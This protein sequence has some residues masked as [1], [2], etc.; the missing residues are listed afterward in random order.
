M[1]AAPSAAASGVKLELESGRPAVKLEDEDESAGAPPPPLAPPPF[2]LPVVPPAFVPP[3]LLPRYGK[4]LGNTRI[5]RRVT[6]IVNTNE[7][8]SLHVFVGPPPPPKVANIKIHDDLSVAFTDPYVPAPPQMQVMKTLADALMTR[9]H[10]IVEA[11]TGTGK[12]AAVFTPLLA[13]QAQQ[14]QR[15]GDSS[16]DSVLRIIYVARTLPQLDKTG[17]ELATYPYSV[18]L[19]APVAKEHLCMLP[20]EK[21]ITRADQCRAACKPLSEKLKAQL[22][23]QMPGVVRSTGCEFLDMQNQKELPNSRID[24]Y[25]TGGALAGSTV[26]EVKARAAA[27]GICAY[28]VSRDL[29]NTEGANVVMLTYGQLFDPHLRACNKTD[30]LLQN[31][32]VFI[33]EAHNVPDVSRRVASETLNCKQLTDLR[34]LG[35]LQ[36]A[37]MHKLLTALAKP[38]YS[39]PDKKL[40]HRDVGTAIEIVHTVLRLIGYLMAW[41]QEQAGTIQKQGLAPIVNLSP[42]CWSQDNLT[43][44]ASLPGQY[45]QDLICAAV[46]NSGAMHRPVPPAAESPAAMPADASSPAAMPADAASVRSP[47]PAGSPNAAGVASPPPAPSPAFE[48]RLHV[49]NVLKTLDVLADCLN[50]V[51][52]VLA[53]TDYKVSGRRQR[54]PTGRFV[55]LLSKL[56]M[57]VGAN[58]DSFALVLRCLTPHGAELDRRKPVEKRNKALPELNFACLTASLAMRRVLQLARCAVFAS[59]TLGAPL[60]FALEVGMDPLGYS[61]RT[62]DHHE[63]VKTQFLPLVYR[64]HHGKPLRITAEKLEQ[65][66][67]DLP[68]QGVIDETGDVLMRCAPNV[69]GGILVFFGSKNASELFCKR[70]T[71]NGTMQYLQQL[72]P[73]PDALVIEHAKPKKEEIKKETADAGADDEDEEDEEDDA[74]EVALRNIDKYCSF[75]SKPSTNGKPTAIMF[76]VLRGRC[77]EGADFKDHLARAVF[78]IGVPLPPFK[79]P[80]VVAKKAYNDRMLAPTYSKLSNGERW[81][82]SE[83]T[84]CAAQAAGRVIR[85]AGDHGAVVLLDSR[86][87]PQGLGS[88]KALMPLY[89]RSQQ[90][91]HTDAAAL[92]SKL[93][94]FF[95]RCAVGAVCGRREARALDQCMT[96]IDDLFDDEHARELRP[97]GPP[98]LA[99]RAKLPFPALLVPQQHT[100]SASHSGGAPRGCTPCPAAMYAWRRRRNSVC[101]ASARTFTSRATASGRS[102]STMARSS[103]RMRTMARRAKASTA[104]CSGRGHAPRLR[105]KLRISANRL[106]LRV[107]SMGTVLTKVIMEMPNASSKATTDVLGSSAC[108]CTSTSGTRDHSHSHDT[109]LFWMVNDA[110]TPQASLSARMPRTTGASA[111]P[112]LPLCR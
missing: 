62:T 101:A 108:A 58:A 106:M 51:D 70:W 38:G 2:T 20:A 34:N 66:K 35:E 64:G 80:F 24:E 54:T 27:E 82:Y 93:Q 63:S 14:Q 5:E 7:G 49:R 83:A 48:R 4:G 98:R 72:L 99:A 105:P 85:H 71:E 42:E 94:P 81:Y 57:C 90:Q 19:G 1:A 17:K 9:K 22:E 100:S 47:A 109:G 104:R 26:E 21:G 79:D 86:Y 102:V 103:L 76:A 3:L 68:G 89:L 97:P 32:L 69:P 112:K 59:G 84:R 95:Q 30:A 75:A 41:L 61:C 91:E 110:R 13:F 39:L 6:F 10:C 46:L 15:Y 37:A 88:V 29:T 12:T 55:T 107:A 25:F 28:H 53:C 74:M 111:L 56:E 18:L 11:P 31:A 67:D 87:A 23:E 73:D 52:A 36:V 43:Q 50:M 44:T 65:G 45:A 16:P 33:D 78:V 96:E 60:D 8:V 40:R 77:A 92:A